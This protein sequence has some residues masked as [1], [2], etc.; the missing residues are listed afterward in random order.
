MYT[1][2]LKKSIG[3]FKPHLKYGLCKWACAP[4]P[5]ILC[6]NIKGVSTL[7]TIYYSLY[8]IM[9]EHFGFNIKLKQVLHVK[10]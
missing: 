10:D 4:A 1:S 5:P 6:E 8:T 3:T 9:I 7:Q 2:N